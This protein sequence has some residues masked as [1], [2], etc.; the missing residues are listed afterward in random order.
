MRDIDKVFIISEDAQ[1]CKNYEVYVANKDGRRGVPIPP[2]GDV[3]IE[4]CKTLDQLAKLLSKSKFEPRG[5]FKSKLTETVEKVTQISEDQN[6]LVVDDD[7]IVRDYLRYSLIFHRCILYDA[8][9]NRQILV[10]VKDAHRRI[11]HA[12]NADEGYQKFLTG[13]FGIVLT[14]LWMPRRN[15]P[16]WREPTILSAEDS[17]LLEGFTGVDLIERL[18]KEN[19]QRPR[20]LA[21]SRYWA[22]PKVQRLCAPRIYE[23]YEIG[24]LPKFHELSFHQRNAFDTALDSVLRHPNLPVSTFAGS[25]DA[26]KLAVEEIARTM[27]LLSDEI[28]GESAEI[29][30]IRRQVNSLR[31]SDATVLITGESGTGKEIVARAIHR[32]S[33]RASRAFEAVNCGALTDTLLESE[34][35]GYEKGAFTGANKQKQGLFEGVDGGTLFLDELGD[36]SVAMQVKL[37]RTLQEREIRRVGGSTTLTV[38]VR[39]IAATNKDLVTEI[40]AGRFREDLFYRINVI[41]IHIPPL[42]ERRDDVLLLIERF[43]RKYASKYNRE[44]LITD[45]AMKKLTTHSWRGNVRELMNTIE[46]AVV[47]SENGR[48]GLENLRFDESGS[49]RDELFGTI[50]EN[51]KLS[52]QEALR[53]T[54]FNKSRAANRLGISRGTLYNKMKQYGLSV[55]KGL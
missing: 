45:P 18:A 9:S 28:V 46:R 15:D 44:I 30:E 52:L 40:R 38:D 1:D 43:R 24:V 17:V 25:F 51:E 5:E 53:A 13:N 10:L 19:P 23:L 22:H 14:D 21:F 36:M 26:L 54:N 41:P 3:P 50:R 20:V 48:I 12:S 42:R 37:L 7:K 2:I 27:A 34:L 11:D 49:R 47:M 31:N 6:I 35:F 8:D 29:K 4:T 16:E 55:E 39:I 32:V 33:P